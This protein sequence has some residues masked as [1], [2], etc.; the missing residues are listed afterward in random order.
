MCET[1]RGNQSK[2]APLI[3]DKVPTKLSF[4]T[5]ALSFYMGAYAV[6]HPGYLNRRWDW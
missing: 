2:V 6:K 4:S 3:A 5:G 1:K